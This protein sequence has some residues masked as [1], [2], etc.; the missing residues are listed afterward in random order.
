VTVPELRT[1][2]RRP[3]PEKDKK[4]Q[5]ENRRQALY[6]IGYLLTALFF[7]LLFP[8]LVLTPLLNRKMEI[9]YSDFTNRL[10]NHQIVEVTIGDRSIEGVMKNPQAYG[11]PLTVPF[12]SAFV[13]AS[14]PQ[15]I[16]ELR[17][18]N[19]SYRFQSPPNPISGMLLSS[20]LPLILLGGFWYWAFGRAGRNPAAGGGMG[21]IFGV[22]KS[23]AIEIKP[24]DV[25]VTYK[26]VGGA[27][28]AIAEL[29]EIIQFLKQPEQFTTLGGRIPKGVMLVGPPGTGKTL[30]AKATAGEAQVAFFETSGSEFVEMF[31]GVGAARVRDLFEQARK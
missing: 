9:A 5:E 23:R 21:S 17:A 24:E 10:T 1:S 15:L 16:E 20:V 6:S 11:T 19:V 22:G 27:D 12:T 26:D 4:Q 30:L 14:D 18:A 8:P 28:E 3:G 2:S 7:L 13:P 25:K 29:Q 31:V